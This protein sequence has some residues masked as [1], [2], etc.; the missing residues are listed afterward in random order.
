MPYRNGI[1][2]GRDLNYG[3]KF[4]A[5]KCI[6]MLLAISEWIKNKKKEVKNMKTITIEGMQC[7]HCKMTVEKALK[8][9]DGVIN[10]DVNLENKKAI[11]EE[12]KE[13]D[14]DKIK[15]VI[16]EAGFTVKEIV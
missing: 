16:E 3:N 7:N 9:I 14:N 2:H 4:V 6:V 15:K 8:S 11:I 12:E 10:A 1:L 13:I 5:G